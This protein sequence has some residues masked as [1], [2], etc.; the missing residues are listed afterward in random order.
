MLGYK[1]Y[2]PVHMIPDVQTDIHGVDAKK[3]CSLDMT[4][5]IDRSKETELPHPPLTFVLSSSSLTALREFLP[6]A[7]LRPVGRSTRRRA[8]GDDM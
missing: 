8:S 2:D 4:C 6:D 5:I 3:N 1:L 7:R